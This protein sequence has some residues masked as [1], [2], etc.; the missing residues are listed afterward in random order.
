MLEDTGH[1]RHRSVVIADMLRKPLRPTGKGLAMKS[2]QTARMIL[3]NPQNQVLL[4]KIEDDKVT[5]LNKPAKRSFWVTPGGKVEPGETHHQAL[6]REIREETGFADVYIGD[7]VGSGRIELLW[8][9]EPT[10]LEETFYVVRSRQT[11]VNTEAMSQD[12]K[13]VNR[14]HSWFSHRDLATCKEMIIP[15]ELPAL[16]KDVIDGN[17]LLSS[18]TIDLSTPDDVSPAETKG[19][20]AKVG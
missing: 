14:G 4:Q 1:R 7:C 20:S 13:R 11:A 5:D 16:V 18:R 6:K 12:E 8:H 9:G 19:D 17:A 3:L 2:R 10:M 15:A